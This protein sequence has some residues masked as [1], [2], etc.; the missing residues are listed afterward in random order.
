M[1]ERV[2]FDI[3]NQGQTVESDCADAQYE[4]TL[5][6]TTYENKDAKPKLQHSD[7]PCD[8]ILSKSADENLSSVTKDM[9]IE[10]SD[11]NSDNS[12]EI[13]QLLDDEMLEIL[14]VKLTNTSPTLSPDIRTKE[15]QE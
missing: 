14:P 12:I 6:V 1:G 3:E 5:T 11:V 8:L 9:T 4:Q 10:N 7:T 2:E 13:V 15:S